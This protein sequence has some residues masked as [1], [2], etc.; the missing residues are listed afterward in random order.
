MSD[1]PLYTFTSHIDGKNA[2]VAIWPDRIEWDRKGVSGGKVGAGILTLGVS[3]LF[4]GLKNG[5]TD[6]V[7]IR[8]ITSVTS[9]KGFGGNT[10]VTVRSAGGAVELRAT[11]KEASR[12]REILNRLMLEAQAPTVVSVTAAAPAADIGAQ[13]AQLGQLRDSG[14][15]TNE[16]FESKKAELLARF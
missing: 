13:L 6:M 14:V 7:P 8:Q 12:A 11:H 1:Q 16:E 4:T 3:T 9:K 10:V 2:K 15:L 5:A